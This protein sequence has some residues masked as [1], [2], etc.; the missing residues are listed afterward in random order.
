MLVLYLSLLHFKSEVNGVTFK[1]ETSENETH[2]EKKRWD[3]LYKLFRFPDS[4]TKI[5]V[6]FSCI[7]ITSF[8]LSFKN[9]S[10]GLYWKYIS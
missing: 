9:S 8:F 7:Y 5:Q 10:M 3:N 4:K 6:T 2:T 1:V